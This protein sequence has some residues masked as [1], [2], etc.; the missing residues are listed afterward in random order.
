MSRHDFVTRT[1]HDHG[2]ES[3]AFNHELDGIGNNLAAGQWVAHADMPL[4]EAIANG[5]RVKFNGNSTGF[6]DS[7]LNR[8]GQLTEV[9]VA[10]HDL[11]P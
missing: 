11:V 6:P 4:A 10:G 5:D 9:V 3:M 2:I 8:C 1:Q 7:V